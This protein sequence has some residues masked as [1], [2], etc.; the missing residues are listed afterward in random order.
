MTLYHIAIGGVHD[1]VL[2]VEA[3][4][5]DGVIRKVM[6]QVQVH[7]QLRSEHIIYQ[8]YVVGL[9]HVEVRI[10]IADGDR[11]A[12]VDIGVQVRDTRTRDT[13][14]VS[15]SEVATCR[16]GVLQTG[17]RHQVAILLLKV[18]AL[19]QMVLHILPGVLITQ[20]SLHAYLVKVASILTIT[21]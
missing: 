8:R 12:S 9:L 11:I 19:T 4:L 7:H 3:V 6:V 16:D 13:H 18:V 20:T 17:C 14:I 21:C 1:V 10:T 5:R 15:Q 2:I